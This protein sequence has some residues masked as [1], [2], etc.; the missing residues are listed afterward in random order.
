MNVIKLS[1][2][3]LRKLQLKG[4]EIFKYF[5]NFCDEH[6]LLCYFCGG[7]CIGALRHKGFIPWDDDVDVFM[8]RDDYE[9]LPELWEKYANTN[10][11]SCNRTT[12]KKFMGNIMTT[13]TDNETK[14]IRPW[15]IGKD[16]H[17]GVMIDVIPL[18][19]CAPEGIKRKMQMVWS[20]IFSLYCSQMVPVNHGRLISTVCDIMLKVVPSKKLRYKVW[21]YAETQMSKYK[22]SE[23][24][25]ITELCSGPKY[26]KNKYPKS[27]FERAVCKGFEDIM[28]PLPVGYDEYLRIAFG[29][30]MKMPPKEKQVPHHDIIYMDLDNGGNE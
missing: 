9:K 25:Y 17:K 15:Q 21:K 2:D 16:G 27:I 20:M 19:G 3:E 14:L 1:D 30:Y 22:I 26:M 11:Y 7:C 18:D 29:D 5:K 13:I 4:L 8:P 24:K 23:S 28:A 6:N 10:K 12:E